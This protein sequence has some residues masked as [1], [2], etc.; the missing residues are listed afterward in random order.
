VLYV[1]HKRDRFIVVVVVVAAAAAAADDDDEAEEEEEAEEEINRGCSIQIVK[2]CLKYLNV[3]N[4]HDQMEK[5]GP[6]YMQLFS[7]TSDFCVELNFNLK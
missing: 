7:E 4:I 3:A 5:I 6:I 2:Y 1:K